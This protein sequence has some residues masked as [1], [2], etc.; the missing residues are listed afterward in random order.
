VAGE[1]RLAP[2]T[3]R[4]LQ[5]AS[6]IGARR[7]AV[8]VVPDRNSGRL[9][10]GAARYRWI[11]SRAWNHF[12]VSIVPRARPRLAEGTALASSLS[13]SGDIPEHWRTG[14]R[15]R[16]APLSS[17][18]AVTLT[19]RPQVK[20]TTSTTTKAVVATAQMPTKT[21]WRVLSVLGL[22]SSGGAPVRRANA[23][24]STFRMARTKAFRG[25][26]S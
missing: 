12:C 20:R 2:R 10:V 6:G 11:A 17:A 4:S 1:H 13:P 3:R 21:I 9:L 25:S 15:Y 5:M 16:R 8:P 7:A 26:K 22:R 23:H 18:R 24:R 19:T 14:A